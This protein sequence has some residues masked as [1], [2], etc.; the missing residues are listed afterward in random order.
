MIQFQSNTQRPIGL[1]AT[2]VLLTLAVL[3]MFSGTIHAQDTGTQITP[4]FGDG[5]LKILGAGFKPNEKVTLTVKIDRGTFTFD[6]TAN[7]GGDF[8]LATGLDLAVGS[9]VEIDARG[10]QGSGSASITSVPPALPLPQTGAAMPSLAMTLFVGFI[11]LFGG[12]LL[13]MRASRR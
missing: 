8:E 12:A 1:L 2:A 10:D 13:A 4:S 6:V 7:G 3:L 5:K 9:S 11:V